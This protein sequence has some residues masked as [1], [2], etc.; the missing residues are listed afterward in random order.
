[1]KSRT[2]FYKPAKDDAVDKALAEYL[3]SQS[4]RGK[5]QISFIRQSPGV[6]EF[7]SR[8][9]GIK[10]EGGRLFVR[11]GG[12]YLGIDEFIDIY[13]P[14]ELEHLERRDPAG[15][16]SNYRDAKKANCASN[17]LSFNDESIMKDESSILKAQTSMSSISPSKRNRGSLGGGLSPTKQNS[18]GS[19]VTF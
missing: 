15:R 2:T 8:R 18:Q 19:R 3:N 17:R 9:V 12:G 11:V 6:Y 13:T 4:D 5:L 7:G 14:K 1:M 10:L 16:H